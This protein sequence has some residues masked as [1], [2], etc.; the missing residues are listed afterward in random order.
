MLVGERYV[1]G[2]VKIVAVFRYRHFASAASRKEGLLFRAW[3][4]LEFSGLDWGSDHVGA[5]VNYW[6]SEAETHT[7][8]K[9][10]NET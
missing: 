8:T 10:A 6:P 3:R 9:R 1:S 7:S 2:Y 5:S 4:V